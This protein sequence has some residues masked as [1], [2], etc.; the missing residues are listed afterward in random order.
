MY[1]IIY[2]KQV[3][4][5]IKKRPKNEKIKILQRF[6]QLKQNPYPSNMQI[7]VKKLQNRVGFRLR[8]GDYRFIYDVEDDK[9]IIYMEEANSRGDI[10]K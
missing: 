1:E 3:V 7:D 9:L 6:E 4:K 10:Y 8:V 5:F 2:N